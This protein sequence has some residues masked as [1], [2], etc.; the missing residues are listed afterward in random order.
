MGLSEKGFQR[1]EPWDFPPEDLIAAAMGN[2]AEQVM[3]N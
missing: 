2:H 3:L 1:I